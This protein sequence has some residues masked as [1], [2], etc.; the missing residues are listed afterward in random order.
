MVYLLLKA[1]NTGGYLL[2]FLAALPF[3]VTFILL[4]Q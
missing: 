2:V 3:I 1:D 4:P